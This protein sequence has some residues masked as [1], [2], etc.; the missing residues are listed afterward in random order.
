MVTTPTNRMHHWIDV[1]GST[2]CLNCGRAPGVGSVHCLESLPPS[3]EVV[4]L[5]K[6][7]ERLTK[8]NAALRATAK[9]EK[10]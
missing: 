9:N 1:D 10:G 6:E 8:E 4:V 7:V 5:R 3:P 2:R